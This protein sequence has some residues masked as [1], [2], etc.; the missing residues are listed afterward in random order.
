MTTALYSSLR[1]VA[2]YFT[3]RVSGAGVSNVNI[4]DGE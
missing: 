4:V 3:P 1:D 2:C